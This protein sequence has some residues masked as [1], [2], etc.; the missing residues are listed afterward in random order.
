MKK[1]FVLLLGAA[2]FGAALSGCGRSF[3]TEQLNPP[4]DEQ[5]YH[6]AVDAEDAKKV[7]Y[8]F[9]GEKDGWKVM[10]QVRAGTEEEKELLLQELDN[11]RA[12]IEEN[13]NSR[14]TITD[15]QYR[16]FCE[17][18][19]RQKRDILQNEVYVSSMTGQYIGEQNITAAAD[20]LL[21]QI[22]RQDGKVVL[23]GGC[24]IRALNAPWYIS[25]NTDCGGYASNMFVPPQ[26]D[27][28]LILQYDEE[29]VEI[30]LILTYS[31]FR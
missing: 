2:F 31:G 27:A 24:D 6:W 23:A 21:Y 25:Y 5:D 4:K 12:V 16:L 20:T 7:P 14:H 9:S 26:E 13:Y 19:D 28:V 1:I 17:Q 15:E 30:P 29:K 8:T 18:N 3:V 22:L 11:E 10:L